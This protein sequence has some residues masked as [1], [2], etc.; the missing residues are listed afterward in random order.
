M[1]IVSFS[2]SV[3]DQAIELFQRVLG[4]KLPKPYYN[5]LMKY[6][7][8]TP[9]PDTFSFMEN[10]GGSSIRYF[11]KI[12]GDEEWNDIL[13][14]LR[15]YDGRIPSDFLPIATDFGGNKICISIS[16]KEYGKI[17]FWDHELEVDDGDNPTMDNM[18]LIAKNFDDFLDQL[19]SD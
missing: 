17:Y 14:T 6:N 9:E 19:Y 1:Q 11:L 15:A 18:Y 2:P 4:K 8:G 10:E 3:G 7:G 16:G 13:L 5:F 12:N